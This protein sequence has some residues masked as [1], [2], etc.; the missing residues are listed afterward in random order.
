MTGYFVAFIDQ[1]EKLPILEDTS[2][3]L[4]GI[5]CVCI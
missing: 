4:Y 1:N 2:K 5:K 3:A